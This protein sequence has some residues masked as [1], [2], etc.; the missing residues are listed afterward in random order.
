MITIPLFE[1]SVAVGGRSNPQISPMDYTYHIPQRSQEAKE[2][3]LFIALC[4]NRVDGHDFVHEAE[5]KGAIAAVVEKEI[6]NVKIPQIIVPSTVEAF[7]SLG[8]IWRCRSNIPLVAVTGSV[9]KTTTKE[10]ISHVLSI[11]YNT[12]KGRKNY[13][14]QLGVPIELLRL[15]KIAIYQIGSILKTQLW[16]QIT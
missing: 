2:G 16:L 13:N 9:G 10:L 8:K 5:Q 12:H 14:N 1:A 11:K 15:E 7:G 4:G 6:S 3:T